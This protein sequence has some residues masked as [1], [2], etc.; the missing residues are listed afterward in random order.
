MVEGLILLA[1]YST[2]DISSAGMRVLSIYGS[3]DGVMNK[4]SYQKNKS[5]L[6]TNFMEIVLMG[7]NHAGF[8]CYGPQKGDWKADITSEQ[9]QTDTSLA[10]AE[11][12]LKAK[13]N[14]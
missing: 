13:G 10:I 11:F 12:C 5:K 8:G 7:G 2:A 14:E 9:Q 1:S 3:K 4:N 6:P